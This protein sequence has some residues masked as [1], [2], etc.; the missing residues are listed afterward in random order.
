MLA[1]ICKFSFN[2]VAV[3]VPLFGLL[4]KKFSHAV[5]VVCPQLDR[6]VVGDVLQGGLFHGCN[7]G[8]LGTLSQEG[9]VVLLRK[10]RLGFLE[11]GKGKSR[12]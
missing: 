2:F 8:L 11:G 4:A 9:D 3:C 5:R 12:H 1:T 6:Q 7:G 10:H